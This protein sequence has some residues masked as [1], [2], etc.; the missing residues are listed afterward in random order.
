MMHGQRSNCH[1]VELKKR[2]SQ[3]GVPLHHGINHNLIVW[4]CWLYLARGTVGHGK[5][6]L[7]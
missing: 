2:P 5:R 6:C 4:L 3:Q 7:S 1:I